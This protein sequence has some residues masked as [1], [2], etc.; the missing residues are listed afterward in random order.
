MIDCIFCKIVKKEIPAKVVY[1]NE[2]VL[3]FLDINPIAKGHTLVIPKKH[4]IDLFELDDA[5]AGEIMKAAKKVATVAM[6][7]LGAVGIN[8]INSNR[9]EAGQDVFHYHM[10][11]VPR[12][13]GDGIKLWPNGRY[14]DMNLEEVARKIA[15]GIRQ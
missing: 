14:K 6:S 1:E 13:S 8:L 9:K 15:I 3:A 11:I 7:E 2:H 12:Y 4:A 10:H 5:D